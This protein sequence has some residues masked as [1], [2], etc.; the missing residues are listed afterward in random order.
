MCIRHVW[1]LV[2]AIVASAPSACATSLYASA[3]VV[4]G[5]YEGHC[6]AL[7]KSFDVP[8]GATLPASCATGFTIANLA[9]GLGSSEA[10]ARFNN[11]S[12]YSEEYVILGNGATGGT[13]VGTTSG[14]AAAFADGLHVLGRDAPSYVQMSA[15]IDGSLTG[16]AGPG[17]YGELALQI[18]NYSCTA[19][20]YTAGT[21]SCTVTAPIIGVPQ[22]QFEEILE[23]RIDV[24]LSGSEGD[25]FRFK[26]DFRDTAYIS[27]IQ[28]L[29][30]NMQPM[31]I[32]FSSDSGTPYTAIPEPSGT[33]QIAVALT[34]TSV[35]WGTGTVLKRVRR[36]TP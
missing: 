8:Y 7:Q 23:A 14:A 26:A 9:G 34:L 28:F 20:V 30:K 31:N 4:P 35:L 36:S 19:F 22:I 13:A 10:T 29:D 18:N 6:Q 3:D 24:V 33:S 32:Q 27:S 21:N 11:L 25:Q 2:L 17:S 5:N 12:A 1:N 15:T 16:T